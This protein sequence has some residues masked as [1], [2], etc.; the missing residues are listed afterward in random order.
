MIAKEMPGFFFT[1]GGALLLLGRTVN[2]SGS[3]QIV[4]FSHL[5]R[6]GKTGQL[7]IFIHK[8]LNVIFNSKFHNTLDK[9]DLLGFVV[10]R[11]PPLVRL[12]LS[13]RKYYVRFHSIRL[14]LH[15][16]HR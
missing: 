3:A 2:N 10:R 14:I 9:V 12:S 5:Q 6:T 15:P 4:E 16:G 8:L 7:K 11:T 1:A 13:E